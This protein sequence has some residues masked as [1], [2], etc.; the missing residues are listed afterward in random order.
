MS[1]LT[2]KVALV[3]G[4]GSGIGRSVALALAEAGC[5]LAISGRRL[6]VL[7]RTAEEIRAC[8]V[9]AVPIEGDVS[10]LDDA[11]AMVE[12]TVDEL[13]GLHVLVNNAGVAAAGPFDEVTEEQVH[14]LVDIDLKGPIF[15]LH[16]ALPHLR[17]QRES[18]GA[19]VINVSS[20]VTLMALKNYA[21]YSAAKAGVDMLTRCLALE[22][23]AD[24]IRVNAVCP[25]VVETPIFTT[26]MPEEAAR[27]HL[28]AAD[29]FV[30]L[31]R[32]GQPLDIAR[33][34]VFLAS[35]EAAWI[36]GAVL[37]VDG[38]LSLGPN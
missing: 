33:A 37:P 26:M 20:S 29:E 12:R 23:A 6:E 30:P 10:R 11:R 19:V 31:G 15:V 17:R 32:R 28:E 22:L 2:G 34:V 13:R 36:T 35:E 27:Q 5:S 14:A 8:G 4:G 3:T 16:A 24:R 18:G 9:T 7:E 25:G 38:G 1:P 21:V